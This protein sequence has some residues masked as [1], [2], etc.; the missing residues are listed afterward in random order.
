MTSRMKVIAE[1]E[2]RY[3]QNQEL[4]ETVLEV[5]MSKANAKKFAARIEARDN[6][7]DD[8]YVAT[9]MIDGT[10]VEFAN[11]QTGENFDGVFCD[12][13]VGTIGW[14]FKFTK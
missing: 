14:D 8:L 13:I 1:Y 5:K 6:C 7:A 4:V 9:R 12:E 10:T 2:H 3:G 11:G